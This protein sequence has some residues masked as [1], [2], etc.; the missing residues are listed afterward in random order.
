MRIPYALQL[1]D[2]L[3][4]GLVYSSSL[5][6]KLCTY[7]AQHRVNL[8]NSSVCSQCESELTRCV[9]TT[10]TVI[11]SVWDL[12]MRTRGIVELL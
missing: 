6:I 7:I 1:T 11:D 8:P 3:A 2:K 4:S 5:S 12:H 10:M 9:A